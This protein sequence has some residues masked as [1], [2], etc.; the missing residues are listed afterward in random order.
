MNEHLTTPA[1]YHSVIVVPNG[2]DL[3]GQHR[4]LGVSAIQFKLLPKD[5]TSA[6]IIENTFSGKGGPAQHLHLF[7]DEWFYIVRGEFR[8]VIG[9]EK[10]GL[11]LGDSV[12]GPRNVP[13][14]W[15]CA[16]EGGGSILISFLPAGKMEAFF[17][18]V[19]KSNAIPPQDPELWR[20]HD[21]ELLGPQL[22]V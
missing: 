20:A 16:S 18:E 9:Q 6:L 3:Y 8:F 17:R 7:Q 15:A 12:M 4:V 10:F 1:E 5:S 19:T 21:M 22:A 11:H 2:K 14:V 13:H